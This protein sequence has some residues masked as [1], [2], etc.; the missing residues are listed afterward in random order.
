MRLCFQAFSV[1]LVVWLVSQPN[2]ALE[3]CR[4]QHSDAVCINTLR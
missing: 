4:Q 3:A 1:A 2:A